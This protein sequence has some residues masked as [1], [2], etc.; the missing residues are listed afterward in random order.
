MLKRRKCDKCS[1]ELT[2]TMINA[3]GSDENF[4]N[5]KK[6]VRQALRGQP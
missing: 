5:L 3:W 1:L 6:L 4:E 2:K